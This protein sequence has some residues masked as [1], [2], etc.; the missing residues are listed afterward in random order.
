MTKY[1]MSHLTVGLAAE[2]APDRI[3][4]DGLW[5]RTL[6]DTQATRVFA[7]WFATAGPWRS[8]QVVAD[9][10]HALVTIPWSPGATGRLLLDEEVL[11]AAGVRDLSGYTVPSPVSPPAAGA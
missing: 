9:A 3:A 2:L 1:A 5:P 6:I 7:A 4:V 10:C 11:A 8:P